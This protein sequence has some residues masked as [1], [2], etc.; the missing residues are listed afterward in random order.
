MSKYKETLNLPMTDFPMKGKPEREEEILSKWNQINVYE[1]LRGKPNRPEFIL[2]DGPPYA[3]GH[4]HIGHALNKILKDMVVRSQQMMGRNVHY[5]PGWDCHGLPIEWKIA[6]IHKEKGEHGS[7]DVLEFRGQCREFADKWFEIQR[8]E[9]QRLGLIGDWNN[10]YKTMDYHSERVI[11]EEFLKFLMNGTLYR[12]SKPVMWSPIER[13]T[14][15]EAEVEYKDI[16]CHTIS[17]KF[18]IN[19]SNYLDGAYAVAWTTTPWSIPSDQAVVYGEDIS[20]GLYEVLDTP[21]ECWAKV[22]DRYV[23]NDTTAAA[24]LKQARLDESQWKRVKTVT[25]DELN[26]CDSVL[27]P[28]HGASGAN[29]EW[30]EP[31]DFRVAEFVRDGEGTGFVHCAPSHGIEEFEFYRDLGMVNDMMTFNVM[32]DSS[33]REDMPFFGG[34]R[35]FNEKGKE[36]DTDKAVIDKLAEVGGLLA[37]GR[38]KHSYP[39]SWRSKA[40][41][42][43][44]NTPQWF[45]SIDKKMEDGTS[46]RE[47]ALNSIERVNW[48][49]ES[50][51]NRIQ[52]MVETR[53]DWVLS[54]QRMWGVPL[55]CF[56][57]KNSKMADPDYI[58]KDES[59]NRRILEAFEKD[60][61]DAWYANDASFFLGEEY[62]AEDWEKMNDILDVW[63]DSGSTHAFVLNGKTADLYLEGTD[64]HRGWFQS[65]LLQ[66]CG[67]RGD[68]PYREVLTHG[69]TLDKDGIKM[70]KSLGN[71]VSPNDVVKRYGADVLRM[72]VAQSSYEKDQRIGDD[73]LKD[74][75]DRHRKIRNT[76]KF[77]LGNLKHMNESDRVEVSEMPSL[78][79]WVM[80]RLSELDAIVHEGYATYDF[81]KVMSELFD[82]CNLDLSAFYFDI[83][84]DALYCDGNSKNRRASLTVMEFAL[85]RLLHCFAP[86]LPFTVEEA[87]MQR[88]E[89]SIHMN[90]FPE[91]SAWIDHE[92][93][94]EWKRIREV[95][96]VVLMCLESKREEK[97]IGSSLEASPMVIVDDE[98]LEIL[99][100]VDFA[101]VCIA[102]HV[103]VLGEVNGS[104]PLDDSFAL[105]DVENVTV[106]FMKSDGVQCERCK[107]ILLE[108]EFNKD[109][110]CE[111]CDAVMSGREL[112]DLTIST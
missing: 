65:S 97:V 60:G 18:R 48:V 5:V 76:I 54:R 51:R 73:I 89:G 67:T 28:L 88:N 59:V 35:I 1:Q 16:Q 77:M 10:P 21:D 26:E 99:S 2:H 86:I 38:I 92:L 33:M 11:A 83:R 40:P 70:S 50:G 47:K 49:P 85:D 72:W 95:R 41:V 104:H 94:H 9:F 30:D 4:L 55:T 20:Y 8:E 103:M 13:T 100:N 7:V 112:N 15:A 74:T 84:K 42:I 64:Q 108:V 110:L 66:S 107:K 68:A 71:I 22:G 19:S 62:D 17:V 32:E 82:F 36:G 6:E 98:M 106:S 44:R 109:N 61:A 63:F 80:H 57:R 34:T 3:N 39:H 24:M 25:V 79:R 37:R 31:R 46:I 81:Q 56:V 23:L 87:W 78:E 101:D 27:H 75:A 102:S 29:G 12:G 52:S 93:A 45:V 105:P 14:L 96:K 69:F 90:D 43:Y 91:P 111:R 53:P 58:L